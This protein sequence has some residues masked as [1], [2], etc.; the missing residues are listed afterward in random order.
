MDSY[1]SRE[2]LVKE[3]FPD[4]IPNLWCPLL[5][6]YDDDKAIDKDRMYKHIKSIIR[7]VNTFLVPGST[8]DGW[9]MCNEDRKKTLE[10]VIGFSHELKFKI[11][12]GILET[13]KDAARKNIIDTLDWLREKTGVNDSSEC[14]KRS[15][16]CGF[17]VCPPK[18][19]DLSQQEIEDQLASILELDVPTALYQL[20]QVTQN[21]V[22]PETVKSLVDKYPNLYLFKDTSGADKVALS[23]FDFKGLFLV[24][25]AEGG[26]FK[27]LKSNKGVYDGFLLSTANCFGDILAEILKSGGDA[28]KQSFLSSKLSE[29]AKTVF[30]ICSELP[31]GNVF[32]NANKA[33]DHFMAYGKDA[34]TRK[35]PMLYSENR[36]PVEIIQKV[37]SILSEYGL[38]PEK[39]YMY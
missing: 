15:N 25:G 38:M 6:H 7:N 28:N 22:S 37:G 3:M 26:Y 5:T 19:S 9:E 13:G 14:L 39:G 1:N 23:G 8:G 31:Y 24:R 10:Y 34:Y 21:E 33:V 36:I 32:T 18:G 4:G 35:P 30:D 2:S 29:L 12:V 27:W 11:L 17:T 20:P 16:I